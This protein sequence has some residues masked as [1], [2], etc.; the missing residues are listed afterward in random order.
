[1]TINVDEVPFFNAKLKKKLYKKLS[2]IVWLF[3]PIPLNCLDLS[4]KDM[5]CA[6]PKE[7]GKNKNLN[8]RSLYLFSGFLLTY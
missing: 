7:K 4:E 3:F 6:Y 1:M 5:V 2:F 8:I